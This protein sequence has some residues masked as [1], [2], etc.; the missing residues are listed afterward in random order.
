MELLVTDNR[1]T[2]DRAGFRGSSGV[3]SC[4]DIEFEMCVRHLHRDSDVYL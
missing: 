4:V 2:V 1:K 3:Q